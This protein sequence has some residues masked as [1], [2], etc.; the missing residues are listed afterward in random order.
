M[1]ARKTANIQWA[2]G[3]F[4]GATAF[5]VVGHS[6]DSLYA[7]YRVEVHV[8]YVLGFVSLGV[9]VGAIVLREK[10]FAAG[11]LCFAALYF[12]LQ[13]FFVY[14]YWKSTVRPPVSAY[15]YLVPLG[16]LFFAEILFLAQG[17]IGLRTLEKI[18]KQEGS[19]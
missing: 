9:Y 4:V 7:D 17:Y 6:L 2:V 14:W 5:A 3:I 16:L 15:V 13:D 18:D 1:E 10:A 19:S 11:S 12:F 8:T